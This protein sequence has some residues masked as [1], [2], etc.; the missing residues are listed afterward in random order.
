MSKTRRNVTYQKNGTNG[1]T[2]RI[3]N[4]IKLDKNILDPPKPIEL[5]KSLKCIIHGRTPNQKRYIQT[6]KGNDITICTG[7]PG[8]GKTHVAVG[9]SSFYLAKDM[10]NRVIVVRPLVPSSDE[11]LGFLPGSIE[12]KAGPY[13]RP[14]F[15]EF[16][17]FFSDEQLGRFTAGRRP[18]I[19]I[20]PLALMKG[21]TFKSSFIILDEAQ[22]A[23]YKQLRMFLTRIGEGSKIVI[24]GDLNQSDRSRSDETTSLQTVIRKLD[25]AEG[26]GI[27]R[28]DPGD[29]QR[30]PRIGQI[31]E[32]L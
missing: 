5:D 25:G 20:V 12:D 29:I 7:D 1:H 3:E 18:T 2:N 28:L 30:H 26:V 10:V 14:I 19:E 6:I 27:C 22:D 9:M 31:L 13:L 24:V 17:E 11:D 23:T 15:D 32:R 16:C 8:T 21:R 4:I